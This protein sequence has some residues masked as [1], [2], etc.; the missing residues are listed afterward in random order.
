MQDETPDDDETFNVVNSL[1]KISILYSCHNINHKNLWQSIIID[2]IECQN[3]ITDKSLPS[4]VIII[5]LN[6]T[7]SECLDFKLN[8]CF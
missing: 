1:K 6:F 3:G 2:I 5:Y 4:E 8:A 7:S